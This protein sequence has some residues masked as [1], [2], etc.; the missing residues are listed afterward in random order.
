MM[1]K[2]ALRYLICVF[3]CFLAFGTIDSLKGTILP[4]FLDYFHI[5]YSQG[6]DIFFVS[7]IGYMV[8]TLITG[9]IRKY[10]LKKQV[11]CLGSTLVILATL[12]FTTF[13]NF[14]VMKCF[15]FLQGFGIG[16]IQVV[17]NSLIVDRFPEKKG[18]YLNL[19][20]FFHGVGLIIAPI[21]ASMLL[22]NHFNWI[23]IYRCSL[24]FPFVL[25]ILFVFMKRD[26]T[27]KKMI[28]EK[29]EDS[30]KLGCNVWL[31]AIAMCFYIATEVSL[32]SWM[33]EFL[34]KAKDIKM[35]SSSWILSAFFFCM[36]FG[37]L[38]GSFISEKV[39]FF[40]ILLTALSSG[41][42][43]LTLGIVLPAKF[44]L[45]IPLAGVFFSVIFPTI[46][47]IASEQDRQHSDRVLSI[48]FFAGGLGGAIGSLVVGKISN[49]TSIQVGFSSVIVYLFISLLLISILCV[50][51]K[52][53]K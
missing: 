11:V 38:A 39:S 30:G 24:I 47:A 27:D 2:K 13:H 44:V 49:L 10:L 50:K 48:I 32:S 52:R 20:E 45:L 23:D 1:D 53:N 33:V 28:I 36:T 37:R 41:I 21:I 8:S 51:S 3:Y 40:K 7:F 29:S 46:V 42:V 34:I 16:N 26:D 5:N 31:L 35:Q 9:Y 25:L 17:G 4:D 15:Y 22:S 43:L 6:S 19:L 14:T 18:K 12:G